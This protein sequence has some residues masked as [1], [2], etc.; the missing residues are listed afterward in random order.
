MANEYYQGSNKGLYQSGP[1]TS[2]GGRVAQW[3]GNL[4]PSILGIAGYLAESKGYKDIL[5]TKLSL[6]PRYF[7]PASTHRD[8]VRGL[9]TEIRNKYS[10]DVQDATPV[11]VRSSDPTLQLVDKFITGSQRQ[12]AFDQ[13]AAMESQTVLSERRRFGDELQREQFENIKRRDMN[14]AK[15]EAKEKADVRA[16]AGYQDA[17]TKLKA[18]GIKDLTEAF[19]GEAA[20]QFT[21]YQTGQQNKVTSLNRKINRKQQAID[22]LDPTNPV[23][24]ALI[25]EYNQD[26]R[27]LQRQLDGIL[28][29]E[30]KSPADIRGGVY[31][32]YNPDYTLVGRD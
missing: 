22:T 10:K 11:T 6:R 29:A 8:P 30:V 16:R 25:A 26:L 12:K 7:T 23:D 28:N 14:T 19:H 20:G 1:T 13:L 18:R 31:P 5:D 2:P 21:A 32:G 15:Q 9:P 3:A 17:M 4:T 27:D 24:I